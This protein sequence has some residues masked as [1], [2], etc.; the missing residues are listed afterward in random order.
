[1]KILKH[2]RDIDDYIITAALIGTIL[3]VS[4]N[5]FLRYVFNSPI[6]WTEEVS[7]C[8]YI[9]VTFFGVSS[10]MKRNKHV[11]IDYIIRKLPSSLRYILQWIRL[12]VIFLIIL[13]IFVFLGFQF[14]LSSTGQTSVLDISNV[15]IYLAV[16]LGGTLTLIHL[17]YVIY[18]RNH[19]YIKSDRGVY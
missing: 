16:P 7:V 13:F 2:F 5:I 1:M 8:L 3:V 15:F 11:G 17:T 10:A 18:K 4:A 9:Y 14:A 6:T 19:N 12:I